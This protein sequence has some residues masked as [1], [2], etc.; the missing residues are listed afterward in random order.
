V[1]RQPPAQE[2][3]EEVEPEIEGSA[4]RH[5]GQGGGRQDADARARQ[6]A[7][8]LLRPWLLDEPHHAVVLGQ[9]DDPAPGRVGH[10]VERERRGGPGR[11]VAIHQGRQ[12]D[13]G[14]D[15][16]IQDEEGPVEEPG[17]SSGRPGRAEQPLLIGVG[18]RDPEAVAVPEIVEDRLRLVVQIDRDLG[19]AM[20]TQQGD[21]VLQNR[22][23]PDRHHRLG[24]L[25]RQ[26]P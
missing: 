16:P 5:I 15:I 8:D 17:Q 3:R 14:Q 20:P 24:P 10:P 22:A 19:D 18:E 11:L 12:V 23:P 26:G 6:V 13:V 25:Q 1:D 21:Q 7:E 4:G 2:A 9:L